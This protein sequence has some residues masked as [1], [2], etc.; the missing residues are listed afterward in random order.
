VRVEPRVAGCPPRPHEALLLV[1]PQ[2]LR[3]HADELGGDADHV[4][5]TVVHQMLFPSSSSKSRCFL[6]IFFGTSMRTRASTSPWPS[7]FK[8]RAPR[9]LIRS[10]FPSSVPAGIFSETAPPGVGASRS[11][12]RRVG[13]EGRTRWG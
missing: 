2:R 5:R 11:E 1:H 12:E 6:F 10:S 8:R 9:P 4:A 3:V 7:P 13:K